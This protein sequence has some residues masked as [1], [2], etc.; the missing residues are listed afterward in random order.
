MDERK[1]EEGNEWWEVKKEIEKEKWKCGT[2]KQKKWDEDGN[3]F[4]K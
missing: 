2:K 1:K 3:N 4:F